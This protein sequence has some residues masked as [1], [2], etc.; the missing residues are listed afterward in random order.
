MAEFY[1]STERDTTEILISGH[2]SDQR[3]P[4][5]I[6]SGIGVLVKG[7][8]LGQYNTG[9]N[10]GMYGAYKDADVGTLGLGVARG[11]LSDRVDASSSGVRASMYRHGTFFKERLTGLDANAETDLKNCVFVQRG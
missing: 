2:G 3:E 6:A 9:A 5:M 1:E 4:I 10:S 11:I 7:T 8:V